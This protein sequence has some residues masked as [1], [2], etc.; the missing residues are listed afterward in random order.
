MKFVLS[1]LVGL[2]IAAN[3]TTTVATT[4]A[5]TTVATT[6]GAGP[7]EDKTLWD[8]FTGSMDKKFNTTAGRKKMCGANGAPAMIMKAAKKSNLSKLLYQ[9]EFRALTDYDILTIGMGIVKKFQFSW[10][11]EVGAYLARLMDSDVGMEDVVKGYMK[12]LF[13]LLDRLDQS[14]TKPV[15]ERPT[16]VIS[17]TKVAI[18]YKGMTIKGSKTEA[19]K[20]PSGRSDTTKNGTKTADEKSAPKKDTKPSKPVKKAPKTDEERKVSM[21]KVKTLSTELKEKNCTKLEDAERE[22]C[23][24]IMEK[25]RT[26]KEDARKPMEKKDY[27]KATPTKD[28]SDF[29]RL[30]QPFTKVTDKMR[31]AA[32]EG[33][34]RLKKAGKVSG[35]STKFTMSSVFGAKKNATK[36]AT[37]PMKKPTKPS[38]PSKLT[39]ADVKKITDKAKS[40]KKVPVPPKVFVTKTSTKNLKNFVSSVARFIRNNPKA[41]SFLMKEFMPTDVLDETAVDELS[42]SLSNAIVAMDQDDVKNYRRRRAANGTDSGNSTETEELL[43]VD[44]SNILLIKDDIT[45]TCVNYFEG[46][47]SEF[48]ERQHLYHG[49][50]NLLSRYMKH[51]KQ[52][53]SIGNHINALFSIA[54]AIFENQKTCDDQFDNM[55]TLFESMYEKFDFSSIGNFTSKGIT[56]IFRDNKAAMGKVLNKLIRADKTSD[57]RQGATGAIIFFTGRIKQ[58]F[59]MA[60]GI[61]NVLEKEGEYLPDWNDYS[62]QIKSARTDNNKNFT[63]MGDEIAEIFD[64]VQKESVCGEGKNTCAELTALTDELPDPVE[65]IA[66]ET[67]ILE[68]TFVK[69][70][71]GETVFYSLGLM[72][73][74]MFIH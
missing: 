10:C 36:P 66:T 63:T 9:K 61:M 47:K 42:T 23:K 2:T 60:P 15:Y 22:D 56:K 38:T 49:L 13:K 18:D 48:K 40:R 57:K 50:Y 4:N 28:T 31:K 52:Y 37:K 44:E 45:E 14:D 72:I 33:E 65:N 41:I 20:K 11:N 39:A 29:S 59:K 46:I 73:I 1:A 6:T 7:T 55:Y 70:S 68:D 17:T 58:L 32:E 67:E 26:N 21:N 19:M 5:T 43:F 16:K 27:T 24:I 25:I 53:G 34:D 69:K 12:V 51:N 30:F 35:N 71:G 74:F 62:K 3:G 54:R 8:D 64:V